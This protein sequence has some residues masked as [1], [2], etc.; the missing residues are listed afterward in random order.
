MCRVDGLSI[1][2]EDRYVRTQDCPS[3]TQP[4][5]IVIG[6]V[7]IDGRAWIAYDA[8]LHSRRDG[9]VEAF[10]DIAFADRT[11]GDFGDFDSPDGL[12]SVVFSCRIADGRV[13]ST[14]RP[15]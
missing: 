15:C 5:G 9:I 10:V 1:D 8:R 7:R 11:V 13:S 3:C 2:L 4:D 14:L 12:Y 6:L